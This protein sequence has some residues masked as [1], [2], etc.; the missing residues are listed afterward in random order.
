MGRSK[1]QSKTVKHSGVKGLVMQCFD[2]NFIVRPNKLFNQQS[3]FGWFEM[4][5]RSYD[6]TVI[7]ENVCS[8]FLGKIYPGFPLWR[9]RMEIFSALLAICAGNSSVTDEFTAQ[10]PVTRSV[11]VYFDLR[12]NK[13]LS[14]QSWGWWFETV[15]R[16][17]WRHCNAIIKVC[18]EIADSPVAL[19]NTKDPIYTILINAPK[20]SATLFPTSQCV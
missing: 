9:H 3:R 4:D 12:L 11:D 20:I 7:V 16:P 5:W 6:I 13:M 17:L 14:K 18:I 1:C 19:S 2:Q 8:V 15:S 10:R